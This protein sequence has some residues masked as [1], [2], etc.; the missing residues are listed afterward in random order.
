MSLLT[1]S[2]LIPYGPAY[3]L[4]CDI[5]ARS[6]WKLHGSRIHHAGLPGQIQLDRPGEP[7]RCG[8]CDSI[9]SLCAI[10]PTLLGQRGLFHSPDA[11]AH[12]SSNPGTERSVLVDDSCDRTLDA[13]RGVQIPIQ[14]NGCSMT[15]PRCLATGKDEHITIKSVLQVDE[16]A[17]RVTQWRERSRSI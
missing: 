10:R 5:L 11:Q 15:G 9:S 16:E 3:C 2:R 8:K 17:C 7:L 6:Q 4:E 1:H 13:E 12:W 14:Q